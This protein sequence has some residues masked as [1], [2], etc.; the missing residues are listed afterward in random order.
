MKNVD[1]PDPSLEDP[2]QE[3]NELSTSGPD[4]LR[5]PGYR[6][7]KRLG[8]GGGATVFLAVQ[9]S[10]GRPV[11][12]K[13][14]NAVLNDD[15]NFSRRF[16]NEGRIIAALSHRNIITVH[17]VGVVDGIH[18][19]TMEH[20]AGG[21]LNDRLATRIAPEKALE[22]V[23]TLGAALHVAHQAG[24]VHR[25]VKPGNILFRA[26]GTPLLSD[27]GIAKRVEDDLTLG[28]IVLGTPG[29]LSPEQARGE[30]VDERSDV[31]GLGIIFYQMLTGKRPYQAATQ[32]STILKQLEDPIPELPA[33]LRR[34]QPLLGRMIARDPSDR[35]PDMAAML[36][37]IDASPVGGAHAAKASARS[38][39]LVGAGAGVLGVAVV[40]GLV[41]LGSGDDDE[42]AASPVAE[43]EL[44]SEA[45][46]SQ[47]ERLDILGRK[48]LVAGRLARPRERSALDYFHKALKL[49]AGD[50][51][52]LSGL[53]EI[54]S[55]YAQMAENALA[56]KDF[57]AAREHADLGLEALPGDRRLTALSREAEKTLVRVARLLAS[58]NA[59]LDD[60]RLTTPRGDNARHYYEA[61][62]EI[63]PNDS[64]ATHGM[65]RIV[66]HY[67][68]LAERKIATYQYLDARELIR[69]G[70][71]IRPD[72]SQLLALRSKASVKN[73][74]AQ[75]VRDIKGLLD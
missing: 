56:A 40:A 62:L 32:I 60:N 57:A 71:E 22:L 24:V 75:I 47:V 41:F 25:D 12:I 43:V 21:D 4:T 55:R 52:A 36:A 3:I 23:R 31:Y 63:A 44:S 8:Q 9:E 73:A 61:V 29:Y 72:D 38:P 10:L 69:R 35:F 50:P 6:I 28:N 13:V 70:L 42:T 74:P 49:D 68:A 58:A 64:R 15:P 7:E 59:A 20:V 67:V 34:F 11:A 19:I 46:I 2:R 39:V 51:V 14:E 18:Y 17:D 27:F 1:R 45:G 66:E 5:I 54:A 16:V 53:A 33:R 48:A 65:T 37:E 30:P 26:D